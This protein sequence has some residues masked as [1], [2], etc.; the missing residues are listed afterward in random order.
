MQDRKDS[1]IFDL[2]R[3]LTRIHQGLGDQVSAQALDAIDDIEARIAAQ[4]AEDP[5]EAAIQLMLVHNGLEYLAGELHD[6][7]QDQVKRV[8]KM[9]ASVLQVLVRQTQIDLTEF[10]GDWYLPVPVDCRPCMAAHP[11][12]AGRGELSCAPENN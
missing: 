3:D 6:D 2:G 11:R 5:R 9:V 10:A 12:D 8:I 4:T 7:L 1:S